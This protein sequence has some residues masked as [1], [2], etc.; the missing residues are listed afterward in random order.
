MG[1][2]DHTRDH[3]GLRQAT[4]LTDSLKARA[5]LSLAVRDLRA[6]VI[7]ADLAKQADMAYGRR[8]FDVARLAEGAA[9]PWSDGTASDLSAVDVP[10]AGIQRCVPL[11]LALISGLTWCFTASPGRCLSDLHFGSLIL[12]PQRQSASTPEHQR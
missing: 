5:P 12:D 4:S 9:P 10:A 3:N 1:K 2:A 7:E 6:W 8:R 11:Q